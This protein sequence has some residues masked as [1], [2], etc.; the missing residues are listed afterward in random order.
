MIGLHFWH[1]Y[2]ATCFDVQCKL[3]VQ[4]NVASNNQLYDIASFTA[5]ALLAATTVLVK[6]L[7]S[8][9]S[10]ESEKYSCQLN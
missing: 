10:Y 8:S 3:D 4:T 1:I 2:I 7:P 6:R 5:H 9:I